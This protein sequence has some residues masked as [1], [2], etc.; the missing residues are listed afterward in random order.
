M[1]VNTW[2]RVRRMKDAVRGTLTVEVCAQP[3]TALGSASYSALVLGTVRAPG[4]DPV[5]VEHSCTVPSKRCPVS[6]QSVPVIVDRTNPR[7]LAILWDEV[8]LRARL[9]WSRNGG[10]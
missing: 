3:D 6:G 1:G 8:P 7:R 5:K 10:R 9:P 4:V 2:W